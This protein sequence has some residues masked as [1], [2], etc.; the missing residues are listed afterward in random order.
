MNATAE[1]IHRD[2]TG[3]VGRF[4]VAWLLFVAVLGVAAID[5]GSIAFATFKASDVAQAG[6]S[7]AAAR[8]NRG[9]DERLAC[10]EA[11]R[12]IEVRD[13]DIQLVRCQVDST[14]RATV[15]VRDTASTLVVSRLDFLAKYARVTTTESVGRP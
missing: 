11:A 15:T 10:Q 8:F 6:A 2:E 14:G 9:G 5:V 4:I 7:E 12:A 1:R 3:L 13:P